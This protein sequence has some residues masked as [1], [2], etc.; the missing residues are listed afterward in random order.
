MVCDPCWPSAPRATYIGSRGFV[1]HRLELFARAR[2]IQQ[3]I[4]SGHAVELALRNAYVSVAPLGVSI[5]QTPQRP[6]HIS[7][8]LEH[9]PLGS[10]TPLSPGS[11]WFE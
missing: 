2:F 10:V 9:E 7:V 8:C 5:R 3:R 1:R 6:L 4:R 11:T